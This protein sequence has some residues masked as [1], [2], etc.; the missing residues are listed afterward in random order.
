MRY[1][2]SPFSEV[3]HIGH[4]GGKVPANG[5]AQSDSAPAASGKR[6]PKRL[7]RSLAADERHALLA[8]PSSRY[9]TGVRDR[10]LMATMLFAGLRCAE[11]LSLRPR[12]VDLGR[13]LLRV[14]GKGR[15]ERVVPID[16]L[17]EA[18]LRE[19]RAR[20]PSGDTFFNTLKGGKLNDRAVREMVKRRALKAGLNDVHPH[21]LRH[22]CATAWI[23][24]RRL[25][26]HE[27]QLLLGHA[28]LETT[29]RYLHASVPNLVEK[30]RRFD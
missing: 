5:R 16:P 14:Q 7:P 21:L 30:F 22:T 26:L 3:I 15:K 27:A 2:E 19:W 17:L 18:F 8:Q 10:A 12:D 1:R 23:S 13:F 29:Q 24:E 20:R 25:E 9:P 4:R 6:K 28:K 11:A